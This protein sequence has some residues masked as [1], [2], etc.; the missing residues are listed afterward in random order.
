MD[1]QD[2]IAKKVQDLFDAAADRDQFFR[3]NPVTRG[4]FI[5]PEDSIEQ[6]EEDAYRALAAGESFAKNAPA[7][8]QPLP[9]SYDDREMRKGLGTAHRIGHGMPGLSKPALMT[10]TSTQVLRIT[11]VV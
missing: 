10:S 6:Q 5:G 3:R 11:P 4:R 1:P 7:D 9:L 8:L 2:T